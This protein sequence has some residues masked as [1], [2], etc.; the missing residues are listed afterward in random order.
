MITYGLSFRRC[1]GTAETA[2]IYLYFV[3]ETDAIVYRLD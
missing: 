1:H 3:V 2:D